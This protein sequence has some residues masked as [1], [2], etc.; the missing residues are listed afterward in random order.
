MYCTCLWLLDCKCGELTHHL[1]RPP[2]IPVLVRPLLGPLLAYGCKA[3]TCILCVCIVQFFV[4][5]CPFGEI[6]FVDEYG[7]CFCFDRNSLLVRVIGIKSFRDGIVMTNS[8]AKGNRKSCS[9]WCN[10]KYLS[11]YQLN[12]SKSSSFFESSVRLCT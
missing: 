12:T 5:V 6:I 1:F 2:H 3:C 8:W 7:E 9:V 11:I 4:V 10:G